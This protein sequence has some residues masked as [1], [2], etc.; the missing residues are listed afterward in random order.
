M[1]LASTLPLLA[2]LAL[3]TANPVQA[4]DQRE[5][6]QCLQQLSSD[7]SRADLDRESFL[8]Y[9]SGIDADPSVIERLDWQPEFRTP[10]WDYLSGLVDQ[11]RIDDGLA[12]QQRWA[13]TLSAV[14]QQYSVDA[15]VLVAIWGVESDYGR[16]TG[17]RPVLQSLATL[18]C[19]GRRQS[20]F[21]SE[22]FAALNIVH[23]GDISADDLRGSWAGAFGQSQFMPSSFLRNA[24]DFDGDGRRDLVGSVPDVLAS[25]ANYLR[26]SN[27]RHGEPWGAEAKVPGDL[28][29]QLLGRS[30]RRSIAQWRELGVEALSRPEQWQE[31]WQ[32]GLIAPTGLDGPAFL[33]LRN[34]NALYSYNAAESYALAIAH[35]A[36]R[37]RGGSP[38]STPWPTDDPGLSRA[39]R[40][41]LQQLLIDLGHDIGD[42]DG[43]IG[44]RSRDALS[45]A[46]ASSGFERDG[47]V[48]LRVLEQL[49]ERADA[50]ASSTTTHQR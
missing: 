1:N 7:A 40:R 45:Q 44:S 33:V 30:K 23:S 5:F 27:W 18:S 3:S 36:D 14:E 10:L 41:E 15:A 21:R 47:R 22:L 43:I 4:L 24:V 11:E 12:M 13:E 26:Q 37:L 29:T 2:A 50:A 34:F 25:T 6:A 8:E 49:R 46:L 39:Q 42:V 20:Y 16:I 28:D 32:A 31:S 9:F 35:L 38:W 48:G 19:F 17:E